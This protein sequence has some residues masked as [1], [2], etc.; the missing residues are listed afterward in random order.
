MKFSRVIYDKIR[1]DSK[2]VHHP[3]WEIDNIINKR[4]RLKYGDKCN[5]DGFV[6]GH[7]IVVTHRSAGMLDCL[8]VD[9]GA[10]YEVVFVATICSP[11]RGEIIECEVI[12]KHDEGVQC[13]AI[14][15]RKNDPLDIIM[16]IEWHVNP[17]T[18]R[19]LRNSL[20]IGNTISVEVIGTRYQPGDRSIRLVVQFHDKVIKT[21]TTAQPSYPGL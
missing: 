1:L 2:W 12:D 21:A 9:G 19:F 4:I 5:A 11:K 17:K 16:P 6:Y 7:S 18:I 20:E 8:A 3:S 13:R 10:I 14:D 15:L